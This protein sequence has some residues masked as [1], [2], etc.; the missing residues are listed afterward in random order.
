[1]EHTRSIYRDEKVTGRFGKSAAGSPCSM[2][3]SFSAYLLVILA[4]GC[5]SAAAQDDDDS[6]LA[7]DI[8]GGSVETP[9]MGVG[10]NG[11]E[12]HARFAH[13]LL[14]S[15]Y[16]G[17]PS[18]VLFSFFEEKPV[19]VRGI[20]FLDG[21]MLVVPFAARKDIQQFRGIFPTPHETLRYQFQAVFGDG[22]TLLSEEFIAEPR[23]GLLEAL[24]IVGS[25]RAFP[26]QND[27]LE[28]ALAL[29]QQ[30]SQL[31]YA[32]FVIN[33]FLKEKK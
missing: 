22:R 31:K 14:L 21:H 2:L 29:D 4:F 26:A 28:Q 6:L 32:L 18:Q 7:G 9:A 30:S 20:F 17:L 3:L 23:C 13:N 33:T 11:A 12:K 1:V 19:L 27:L 8:A 24:K 5:G 25:A 16:P 15:S 10:S